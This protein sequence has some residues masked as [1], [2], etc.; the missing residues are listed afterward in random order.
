MGKNEQKKEGELVRDIG[1]RIKHML[2]LPVSGE[3][4]CRMGYHKFGERDSDF[5]FK[6]YRSVYSDKLDKVN[7]FC[8]RYCK[9]CGYEV[10]EH[11]LCSE[12]LERVK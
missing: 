1:Y 10:L 7:T 3:I 8:H 11:F 9:R 2:G 12:R 4:L 5:I 6:N